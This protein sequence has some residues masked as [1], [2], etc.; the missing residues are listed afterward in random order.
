VL[1]IT[2]YLGVFVLIVSVGGLFYPMLGYFL[3]IIFATLF[4]SSLGAGRWFC[5][6]ICPRGSFND[7]WLVKIS[8]GKGIP[9]V[10]RSM[11]VRIPVLIALLGFMAYRIFRADGV[12]LQVGMIFVSMCIITTA[13]AII[14]G[15][16]FSPRAWCS[17][18]PMGT[19]QA[20]IGGK[21][22]ALKFNPGRCTDCGLCNRVCTMQLVVN[23]E[24]PDP[25]CIRCGRC[26]RACPKNALGF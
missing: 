5:G 16:Q 11:R 19:L 13:A 12:V 9:R 8:R 6:N 14:L 24:T 20:G 1:W 26:V 4:F 2:P 3:P 15:F 17:L 7:F 22:N 25:D 21:K 18:C 10:F 23:R